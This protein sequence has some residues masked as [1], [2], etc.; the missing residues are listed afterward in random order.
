VVPPCEMRKS[1]LELSADG[2]RFEDSL[3]REQVKLMQRVF[4]QAGEEAV[5]GWLTINQAVGQSRSS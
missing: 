3:R 5:I 4:E 2:V 1:L